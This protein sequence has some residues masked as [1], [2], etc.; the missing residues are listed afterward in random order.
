M[1]SVRFSPLLRGRS[2]S[3]RSARRLDKAS[4]NAGKSMR[5]PVYFSSAFKRFNAMFVHRL[6]ADTAIQIHYIERWVKPIG[7]WFHAE[8]QRSAEARRDVPLPIRHP[9]LDTG[10]G[11]FP[12]YQ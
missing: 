3:P 6:F 8:T 1:L 9:V 11:F 10:L 12:S 7:F 2:G 4:L 5:R